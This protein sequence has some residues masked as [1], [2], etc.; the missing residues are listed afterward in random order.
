MTNGIAIV[1][2]STSYIPQDLLS[3]HSVSIVPLHVTLGDR[4]GQEGGEISPH[5]VALALRDKSISVSTSRPTPEDFLRTYHRLLDEGAHDIV[6]LHISSEL[7]G[8]FDSAR[9]AAVE[10]NEKRP[11]TRV[12]V[13]DSRITC[14]AMGQAAL[15]AARAACDGRVID[16]VLRLVSWVAE[17]STN[18]FYV[19]T[20][21]YLRR[22]G[23]IGAAQALLGTALAVKPLLHLSDGRIAPLE[24]V[25]T[26]S[27]A[28]SRLKTLAL[29]AAA[30]R[31]NR[32]Q[33]AVQHLA[34]GER[35]EAVAEDL[36]RALPA[37]TSIVVGEVGAVVGAH[38]GPGLLGIALTP[39]AEAL[40]PRAS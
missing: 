40:P 16:D 19:D 35:A 6:S 22:G 27:R 34:A 33:V 20:L 17:E 15:A 39:L 31:E 4:T 26:S 38:V 5:D 10:C 37:D 7:S 1:T 3:E 30:R 8:T 32:V 24:K 13:V 25:R 2:D 23:R 9:T 18:L 11:Q 14:M 29:E 36:A 21:E 12:H 28:I